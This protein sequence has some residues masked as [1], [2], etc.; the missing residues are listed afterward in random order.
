MMLVLQFGFEPDE[1]RSP[2]RFSNHVENRFIYTAT[3]DHDTAR[4]W[5]ESLDPVRKALLESELDA[6]DIARGREP[7]WALLFDHWGSGSANRA[8]VRPAT[9]LVNSSGLPA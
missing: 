9:T 7:W 8:L 6:R 5:F 4:G 3:H 1:P 2:H